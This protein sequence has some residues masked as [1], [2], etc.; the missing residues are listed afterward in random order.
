MEMDKKVP[1]PMLVFD[2]GKVAEE[3]KVG[4]LVVYNHKL[5]MIPYPIV[6]RKPY[7]VVLT[8]EMLL[9]L[10]CDVGKPCNS[11]GTIIG[12]TTLSE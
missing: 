12:F 1:E 7:G 3:I 2:Y 4:I 9:T 10:C 11:D 5:L 6:K 8:G